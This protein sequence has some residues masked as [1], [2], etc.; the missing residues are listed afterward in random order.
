[1]YYAYEMCIMRVKF[2]WLT[3]GRNEAPLQT[4]VFWFI[5]GFGTLDYWFFGFLELWIIG[6]LDYCLYIVTKIPK[7]Q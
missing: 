6:L 4:L 7:N 2:P 1:M 3:E 5:G